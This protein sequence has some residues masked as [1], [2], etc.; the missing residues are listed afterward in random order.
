MKQLSLVTFCDTAAGI[1]KNG[2]VTHVQ[3]DV[4]IQRQTDMKS[5]V[6]IKMIGKTR[7]L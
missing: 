7:F 2:S 1:R 3:M 5:E 4:H 6:V